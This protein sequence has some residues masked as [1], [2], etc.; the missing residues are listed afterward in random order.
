MQMKELKDEKT[1]KQVYSTIYQGHTV[2]G[3]I[4][5][6]G[7]KNARLVARAGYLSEGTEL[8]VPRGL[9]VPVA[10]PIHLH[11][12]TMPKQPETEKM[13]EWGVAGKFLKEAGPILEQLWDRYQDEAHYEDFSDYIIPLKPL[14]AK[15]EVKIEK[16]K[17]S[18]FGCVFSAGTKKF[19]IK[20]TA[21]KVDMTEV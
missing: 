6:W 12:D 9:L 18:P 20:V 1:G 5:R 21:T 17:S 4:K 19:Q 7:E 10:V 2:T 14:E 15:Y 3:T 16:I 11:P 13:N 8:L